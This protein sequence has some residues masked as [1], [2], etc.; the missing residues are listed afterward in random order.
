MRH[1]PAWPG[2]KDMTDTATRVANVV[3]QQLGVD[4]D[5]VR[6]ESRFMEDLG[7]DSLDVVELVMAIEEG[8]DVQIPDDDAEKIA[9]V[10]DAVLYIEAAMV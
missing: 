5:K 2:G 9:T 4:P 7:A 10:K 6:P 1:P 8:F 3:A